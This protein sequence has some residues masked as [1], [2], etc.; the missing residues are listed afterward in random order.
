[1]LNTFAEK[2]SKHCDLTARELDSVRAVN[3]QP[4]AIGAG[5]NLALE[6]DRP[7]RCILVLAGLAST[8]KL[9]R[10]GNR[11][12]AAFHM[13]GDMPDLMTLH[14]EVLDSDIRTISDCTVAFIEHDLLR[15][16]CEKHPRLAA[17]LWRT[18]LIDASIYREWVVN[19]GLRPALSRMAHLLC[20]VLCRMDDRGLAT[21]QVC[22]F[23]ITQAALGD[24]TGL[25]V[26]HV[27]RTI[28]TLR[29][30]GLVTFANGKLSIPDW[31]GLASLAGFRPEYLHLNREREPAD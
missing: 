27:N 15:S 10:D 17:T 11:Q 31:E 25:S 30:R 18:T 23:D 5:H 28:Q 24:A 12:T 16:L 4:L 7:L 20:E 19:V 29:K 3:I 2:L 9:N 26:V 6:G 22:E 8:S 1:M 14:L 13:A 21:E